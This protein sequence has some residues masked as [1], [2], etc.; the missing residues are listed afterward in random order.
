VAIELKPEE[1]KRARASVRRFCDEHLDLDIGDLKAD[2]VIEFFLRELGPTVYNG[3]I[4]DAQAFL[5][6]RVADLEGVCYEPEFTYWP[7]SPAGPAS[8]GR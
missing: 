7:K 5:R 3:A 2:L 4:A 1:R 6:D 8:G